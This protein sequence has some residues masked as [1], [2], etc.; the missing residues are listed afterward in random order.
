VGVVAH[1]QVGWS[2]TDGGRVHVDQQHG[3]AIGVVVAAE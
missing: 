1:F 3:G 2:D